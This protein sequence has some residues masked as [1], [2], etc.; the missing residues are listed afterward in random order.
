MNPLTSI[1]SLIQLIRV[2]SLVSQAFIQSSQGPESCKP[3]PH[4]LGM[5]DEPA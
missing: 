4:F 1:S 3:G 2:F 5:A